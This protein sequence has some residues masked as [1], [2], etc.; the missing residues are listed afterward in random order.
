MSCDAGAAEDLKRKCDSE[1]WYQEL[2]RVWP[3]LEM[4]NRSREFRASKVVM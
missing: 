1:S 4:R 2:A 3:D